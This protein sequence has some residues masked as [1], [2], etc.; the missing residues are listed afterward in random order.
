M[1]AGSYFPFTLWI[2]RYDWGTQTI[3]ISA[4]LTASFFRRPKIEFHFDIYSILFF[5]F[6]GQLANKIRP[7]VRTI[8]VFPFASSIVHVCVIITRTATR[9]LPLIPVCET[10]SF[11]IENISPNAFF[12]YLPTRNLFSEVLVSDSYWNAMTWNAITFTNRTDFIIF[13][14]G[15]WFQKQSTN[16]LAQKKWFMEI[17][18]RIYKLRLTKNDLGQTYWFSLNISQSEDKLNASICKPALGEGGLMTIM[19]FDVEVVCS[20]KNLYPGAINLVSK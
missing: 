18:R 16:A 20:K 13:I 3:K 2:I 7:F 6:S 1:V 19:F 14:E 4:I 11:I 5:F 8:I 9:W 12:A 10:Y 17:L 15:S